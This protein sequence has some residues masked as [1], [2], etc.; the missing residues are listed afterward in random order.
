MEILLSVGWKGQKGMF[1]AKVFLMGTHIL[2]LGMSTLN[3][4][5]VSPSV[6]L[7]STSAQ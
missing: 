3:S 4:I 2:I 5:L 7:S 1:G 6:C